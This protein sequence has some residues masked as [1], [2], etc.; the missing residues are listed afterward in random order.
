MA[1]KRRDGA[2]DHRL[3]ANP[4]ACLARDRAVESVVCGFRHQTQSVPFLFA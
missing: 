2:L 4:L 3:R 1:A